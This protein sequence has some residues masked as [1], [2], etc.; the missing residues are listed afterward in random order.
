V[1]GHERGYNGGGCAGGGGGGVDKGGGGT[2][3][4]EQGRLV[5]MCFGMLKRGGQRQQEGQGGAVIAH[6]KEMK[7]CVCWG[8]GEGAEPVNCFGL[9]CVSLCGIVR[10][11]VGWAGADGYLGL[12]QPAMAS[13]EFATAVFYPLCSMLTANA[14]ACCAVVCCVLQ[15]SRAAQY[16]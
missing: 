4:K 15:V 11:G 1:F 10:G 8:R 12:C 6:G 7:Y 3:S 16:C 5:C 2:D 9:A 14:V 13:H